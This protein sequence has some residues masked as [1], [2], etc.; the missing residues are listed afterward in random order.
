VVPVEIS[1]SEVELKETLT[2][3]TTTLDVPVSTQIKTTSRTTP[4]TSTT[5]TTTTTTT[6]SGTASSSSRKSY[7]ESSSSRKAYVE[8]S[9]RKPYVESSSRSEVVATAVHHAGNEVRVVDDSTTST[10]LATSKPSKTVIPTRYIT[11]T[12]T[13]TVTI[14]KTTVVK[15]LGGP[16]YTSTLLVTKT[17]KSTLVDTV[18]EFHTLVKPT[19]IVETVTTTVS[20][21]SSLYPPEVYSSTYPSIKLRPTP[22]TSSVVEPTIIV[23]GDD[24]DLEE[25]IINETDPPIVEEEE[26]D[27]NESIFVVMTDKNKGSV[28]KVPNNSYET[29]DRDE[30][31]NNNEANNV[32][33]GGIFIASPPSLEVP[34]VQTDRCEPECKASRNELC[35]KVEGVMRCVCRPGFARMFPDRP[36][37]RK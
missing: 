26:N 9:S 28:I 23:E 5:T 20:T 17:E 3:S 15:T 33:L 7:V 14:T 36:C 11:H 19:S 22:S 25:F 12:K 27:Q 34:R 24:D 30:M 10:K 37:I 16:P 13:S 31:L 32:L 4:T 1:S 21:G 29:Q 2:E 8:S 18:T 35:Q 6:T